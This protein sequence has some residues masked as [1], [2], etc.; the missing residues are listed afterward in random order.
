MIKHYYLL[1]KKFFSLKATSPKLLV[2]LVFSATLRTISFFSLPFFAAQIVEY[3]TRA[4][5]FTAA[6]FAG[7]FFIGAAFYVVC[8]H[9]NYWSYYQNSKYIHNELQRKILDKVVTLDED[10]SS[11][12][13]QSEV[14][15]TA[16]QDVQ[17][18]QGVPDFFFDFLTEMFGVFFAT[19]I[20]LFVN[21]IVGG[22]S[23]IATLL[24][25]ILFTY[26]MKRRDY[27]EGVQ[28]NHQDEISSLYSQI[29]DGHKEI[30]AFNM[31]SNLREYLDRDKKL[32]AAAYRRKHFHQ[33]IAEVL[34]PYI[35]GIGRLIIYFVAAKQILNGEFGV[36][37]LVLII[38]Y[39]ENLQTNY[40]SAASMIYNL[41]R[42][43]VSIDRVHKLLNYK[44][45]HM[46]KFGQ[47][48]T[49]D[50]MGQVE[51]KNVSFRHDR[52]NLLKGVSFKIQPNS[53]TAVVGKSGSGKSTILRLLLRL[54][55]PSSGKIL[56]DGIS[57][58][59]YT[60]EVYATNVSIVTQKPFIFDMSIK[61]N[62]DLVNPDP[63]QQIKACKIAGIHDDIM[64]LEKG[65]D[66]P[67]LSD[68]GNFSVG[69]KQL[70]ALARVLLSKSEVLLFDEVTS[71]LDADTTKQIA[72]V[73][74][75]LK[76][77]HTVIMVTHKPELMRIADNILVIDHGKLIS[78]GTHK[79]LITRSR[80]YREIQG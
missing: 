63:D 8:R 40:E 3:C 26:H 48:D 9:Y 73:L 74:K 30:H 2:H 60:K 71:S 23:L 54:Y 37:V 22:F 66:S 78:H 68:A 43:A 70:L 62:L 6:M 28:R 52:R 58:Q 41:S 29:I 12:I 69:Q 7:V 19:G 57:A 55:K 76:K 35:L 56:L 21:P 33:D 61:E 31:K 38:G 77:D 64:R 42:C 15:N 49:D 25:L 72:K 17:V 1:I 46:Q 39:Y 32:W 36:S 67:L 53:L 16:F 13:P 18:N 4:E 10:F 75:E 11:D 79:E 5:Y 14:I 24:S 80:H 59:E 20:L 34:T 51:F 27:H 65:Y 45:R 47:N 50:I 44:T